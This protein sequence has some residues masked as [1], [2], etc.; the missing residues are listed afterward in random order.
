M[1]LVT[2]DGLGGP[3]GVWPK[4]ACDSWGSSASNRY[5]T[6]LLSTAKPMFI[7]FSIVAG[8]RSQTA[9]GVTLAGEFSNAINDC[10]LFVNGVGGT[11]NYPGDCSVFIDWQNWNATM[12]EGLMNFALASMDA[13]HHWCF[14]TWKV[15]TR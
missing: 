5:V 14:W 2:D 3:G 6:R 9:F 4:Q 15:R 1:V 12:K 11:P 8:R 7:P 13:L 10:G